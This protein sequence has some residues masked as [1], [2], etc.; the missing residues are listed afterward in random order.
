MARKMYPRKPQRLVA[1]T[2]PPK[3]YDM[4][5]YSEYVDV[6]DD[7]YWAPEKTLFSFTMSQPEVDITS[8]PSIFHIEIL[9]L[10]KNTAE[11]FVQEYDK[12]Y[13]RFWQRQDEKDRQTEEFIINSR[14]TI[15][16]INDFGEGNKSTFLL[17]LKDLFWTRSKEKQDTF[18]VL[19]TNWALFSETPEDR[20][21]RPKLMFIYLDVPD[22]DIEADREMLSQPEWYFDSLSYSTEI[23]NATFRWSI[24]ENGQR[25]LSVNGW[26]DSTHEEQT[27]IETLIQTTLPFYRSYLTEKGLEVNSSH[28]FKMAVENPRD[29]K[30]TIIIYLM[31][32]QK[33]EI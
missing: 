3:V 32:G 12:P 15:T 10:E 1:W 31:K 18:S 29:N 5:F 28:V 9:D 16:P 23:N 21:N 22:A 14:V 4:K 17:P 7:T 8:P 2:N 30:D 20:L 24:T 19:N 26:E 6:N 33:W 27:F 13:Y 11:S 25:K